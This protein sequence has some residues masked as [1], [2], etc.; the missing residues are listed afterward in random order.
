[1]SITNDY[2]VQFL[3]QQRRDDF[4]AE[5]ANDRLIK[6]ARSGRVGWRQRVLGAFH[7]DRPATRTHTSRPAQVH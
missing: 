4:V 6:I 3:A 7:H 5:A 1:M 2:T